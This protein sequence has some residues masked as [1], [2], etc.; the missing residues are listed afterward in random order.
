MLFLINSALKN[1]RSHLNYLILF[2]FSLSFSQSENTTYLDSIRGEAYIQM[3][4]NHHYKS[5]RSVNRIKEYAKKHKLPSYLAETEHMLGLIEIQQSSFDKAAD[6]ILKAI[7][8]YQV[9]NDSIAL[10]R[11]YNLLAYSYAISNNFSKYAEAVE[12]AKNLDTKNGKQRKFYIYETEIIALYNQKKYDPLI[13]LARQAINDFIQPENLQADNGDKYIFQESHLYSYKMY[14]AFA[15]LEKGEDVDEALK[16]LDVLNNENLESIFWNNP[17]LYENKS[18][19]SYYKA[20][21]FINDPKNQD[22]IEFY[23][24]KTFFFAQKTH[25]S[26]KEKLTISYDFLQQAI[27][28]EA[29]IEKIQ[30]INKN[31]I[32]ENNLVKKTNYLLITIL[33]ILAL[34]LAYYIYSKARIQKTVTSLRIM[35]TNRDHFLGIVSHEMRTPLY[36]LQELFP[37]Y[38]KEQKSSV[39]KE[40]LLQINLAFISLRHALDNS[41]QYSRLNFFDAKVTLNNAPIQL[42]NLLNYIITY[43]N[44]LTIINEVELLEEIALKNNRFDLD[45]GKLTLVLKNLFKNAVEAQG[46][47]F[48]RFIVTEVVLENSRSL[49]NFR[50][51]NDG[52]GISQKAINCIENKDINIACNDSQKGLSIGLILCNN[53]LSFFNS[54]LIFSKNKNGHQ[55]VSFSIH[56]A[57]LEDDKTAVNI[58]ELKEISKSKRVLYVDDNKINLMVT[59]KSVQ[60]LGVECDIAENGFLAIEAIKNKAYDLVLMDINMPEIN[61]YQ[62][63]LE[64]KKIT[65][66]TPIIACTALS[67]DEI[68]E[69]CNQAKMQDILTKPVEKYELKKMI[70][71]YLNV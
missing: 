51:V 35:Q 66:K 34:F 65:K 3:A 64:I 11:S 42:N 44:S 55:E 2:A 48:V 57:A 37:L 61:G 12:I 20:R 31:H 40:Y 39:K 14:L 60:S 46:A 33:C 36:A 32:K 10:C 54:S 59:K 18:R 45:E 29:E 58:T 9:L 63:S 69:K 5:L 25:S 62:T 26:L 30:L 4:Y 8:R 56:A 13:D 53:L 71:K 28:N 23:L 41:L 49:I 7:E 16:I 24:N 68:L 47:H 70:F 27:K 21:S 6:H 50:I 19:I 38:L 1:I 67:K 52:T 43:F 22:S 15:L 17:R